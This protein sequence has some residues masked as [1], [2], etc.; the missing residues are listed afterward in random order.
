[1]QWRRSFSG[2]GQ[3]LRFEVTRSLFETARQDIESFDVNGDKAS[4]EGALIEGNPDDDVAYA[5]AQKQL[6]SSHYF[7]T[8]LDL[9][10][11]IRDRDNA[12]H[13]GFYLIIALDTEQSALTSTRGE[14][15]RK[16]AVGCLLADLHAALTSIRNALE[17]NREP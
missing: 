6:Y 17:A 16:V 15:I 1:M 14:I 8:A 13:P 12:R 3:E 5:I 10:F 9:S 7:R 2:S 11:C 4:F